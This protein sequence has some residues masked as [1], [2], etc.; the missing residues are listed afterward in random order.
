MSKLF[1]VLLASTVLL[2]LVAGC[3]SDSNE[4]TVDEDGKFVFERPIEIIVPWGS[5]GG[6]DTTIRA[7]VPALEDELGVSIKINNKTG[8]GGATGVDFAIKQPA[9]GYTF[10]ISTQSPILAELTGA[11]DVPVYEKTVPVSRLVH[12]TN[13]IIAPTDAPYDTLEEVVEYAEKNPGKLKAGCMT[14][15]GLD[16]LTVKLTFD[17][18]VEPVAYT[19]GAQLNA[20]VMAGHISLGVVGPGEAM[21]LIQSGD[22]KVLGVAAEERLTT[23]ELKDVQSTGELG[24][25][26]FFGPARGIFAAE[27]TPEEAIDAM[28]AAIEKAVQSEDFVDW[29]KSQGLDQRPGYLGRDEFTEWWSEEYSDI[30][31]LLD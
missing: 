20:D 24:I 10:L 11:T 3:G 14:V 5:G 1:K 22:V 25:D 2:F 27:G 15:T 19:E 13:I 26:S 28:A 6:A 30:S 9:D 31:S 23:P 8:A 7:L 12:D 4:P 16:G 21:G 18:N 17:G 29:A